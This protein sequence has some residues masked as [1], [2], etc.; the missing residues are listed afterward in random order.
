MFGKSLEAVLLK[1]SEAERSQSSLNKVGASAHS[2]SE[3]QGVR[4][5]LKVSGEKEIQKKIMGSS[6]LPVRKFLTSF[7][8]N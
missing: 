7:S 8:S 5:Q 2:E 6:F 1:L 3:L 4:N